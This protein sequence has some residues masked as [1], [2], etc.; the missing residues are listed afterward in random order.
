MNKI[1]QKLNSEYRKSLKRK[2]TPV[3]NK[4]QSILKQCKIHFMFQKGWL[5]D[6][7]FISDFYIPKS[8]TVIE[9]DGDYHETPEQQE[10]DRKKDN[11]YKKRGFKVLRFKNSQ[12]LT[13]LPLRD[14]LSQIE[15]MN[16]KI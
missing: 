13:G 14:V 2:A 6:G 1:K 12:V 7:F 3:E 4:M 11:Y 5:K 9:I 10:I 8:R 16:N 15:N